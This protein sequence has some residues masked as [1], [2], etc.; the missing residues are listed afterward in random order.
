[1]LSRQM[2]CTKIGRMTLIGQG[3]LLRTIQVLTSAILARVTLTDV[4]WIL[5]TTASTPKAGVTCRMPWSR[6]CSR[7]LWQ[8]ERSLSPPTKS[9]SFLCPV[10][11]LRLELWVLASPSLLVGS[12]TR[13]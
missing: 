8:G 6:T 9:S 5:S 2:G 10:R 13:A 12:L 11:F 3:P 4:I 7:R 1:M